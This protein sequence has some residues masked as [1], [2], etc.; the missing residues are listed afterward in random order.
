MTYDYSNLGYIPQ[1]VRLLM[2][3]RKSTTKAL[4]EV[5]GISP[6]SIS[7][8]LKKN[9]FTISY[10]EKIA[11]AVDARLEVNFISGDEERI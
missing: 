11:V 4:A 5:S 2:W 8:K 3:K 1:K 10:L 6:S 7:R 9:S